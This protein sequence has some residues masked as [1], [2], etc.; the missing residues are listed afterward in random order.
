MDSITSSNCKLVLNEVFE[1]DIGGFLKR[2]DAFFA[3]MPNPDLERELS[4]YSPLFGNDSNATVENNPNNSEAHEAEG[5]EV[6]TA[7][8]GDAP[9]SR[10]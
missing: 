1:G 3:V 9:Q 5:F 8:R 6:M 10:T 2:A 7:Y 4:E